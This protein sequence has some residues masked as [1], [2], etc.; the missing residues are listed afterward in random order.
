MNRSIRNGAAAVAVILLLLFIATNLKR[1]SKRTPPAPAA[2]LNASSEAFY[3]QVVPEGKAVRVSPAVSGTVRSVPV[4]E[5]EHVSAGQPLCML[6]DAVQK[7]EWI[8]ALAR[9]SAARKAAELSIDQ[10]NRAEGLF[11]GGGIN[12]SEHVRLRLKKELDAEE[13]AAADR[14]ADLAQA[15]LK[16]RT[17]RAPSAGIIYKVDL[18]PGEA[19]L[20]GDA[21]RILLG[22]A[23]LE[24]R[25][26][27]EALWIGRVDSSR[28]YRVFNAETGEALGKAFFS[29]A[30][31][32]LRPKEVRTEDP[33][34]R[35][36]ANYQ[37]AVLH[38][39]PD[40]PGLPIG[41]PVLVRPETK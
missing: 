38:F 15:R 39:E 3:G 21:D 7:A 6:D 10:W 4:R 9:A 26:D 17:V 23:K 40:R 32:Y 37:E 5:G 31:R 28:T 8:A 29:S 22:S 36:S 20:T 2:E 13:A 14:E 11:R 30:S 1:A 27:V 34:E 33:Q 19:F 41:L 25:C 12:E 18:R 35:L 16:E 24:L